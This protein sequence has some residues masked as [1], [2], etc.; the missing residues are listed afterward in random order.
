MERF[1][2]SN[3][4]TEQLEDQEPDG[5]EANLEDFKSFLSILGKRK[6]NKF[7]NNGR[8]EENESADEEEDEEGVEEKEY[9]GKRNKGLKSMIKDSSYKLIDGLLEGKLIGEERE[10]WRKGKKMDINL[11]K[12]EDSI[13]QLINGLLEGKLIG[14]EMEKQKKGKKKE[15]TT[16][17]ETAK[18][19]R[20]QKLN[21]DKHAFL[22]L[23]GSI[24]FFP[25]E[26]IFWLE[27]LK[28]ARLDFFQRKW[29]EQ[30]NTHKETLQQMAGGFNIFDKESLGCFK[31]LTQEQISGF[32][33]Q[34]RSD[35]NIDIK[36]SLHQLQCY[37][38]KLAENRITDSVAKLDITELKNL[39]MERS[40]T[41]FKDNS[42]NSFF[43]NTTTNNI[44]GNNNT[45]T[46]H[47]NI[48]LGSVTTVDEKKDK[49]HPSTCYC[50]SIYIL[51]NSEI[52]S[53][54]HITAVRHDHDSRQRILQIMS[55]HQNYCIKSLIHTVV[56]SKNQFPYDLPI[57][58]G[59]I[60]EANK[61]MFDTFHVCV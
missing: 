52:K 12:I 38:S 7:Q 58:L 26:D 36:Q 11:N 47:Y 20:E 32:L 19:T 43:N 3:S 13:H 55:S 59:N 15:K 48:N 1:K 33:N 50:A 57:I 29:Y 16:R 34:Q 17:M 56:F 49:L 28:K 21:K 40:R 44:N 54:K 53:L 42:N 2:G 22:E 30:S 60:Y 9:F 5:V 46:N 37:F 39:F 18:M 41:M 6:W 23:L 8:G 51:N 45:T 35:H 25:N 61:K 14:E 27:F 4:F 10:I 31:L 24:L